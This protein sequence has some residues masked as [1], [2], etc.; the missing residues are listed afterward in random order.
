MIRN[1]IYPP[2]CTLCGED[3]IKFAET[4]STQAGLYL[5]DQY[6]LHLTC[7][8]PL[9]FSMGMRI[10]ESVP[11]FF[12]TPLALSVQS[13]V[14]RA[15]EH[16]EKPAITLMARYLH[17]GLEILCQSMKFNQCELLSIP[18]RHS[19]RWRRGYSHLDVLIHELLK[20]HKDF[21]NSYQGLWNYNPLLQLRKSEVTLR[22]QRRVRDQ[23]GLGENQRDI[24]MRNS[25]VV[26]L[27][28]NAPKLSRG[29]SLIE[30]RSRKRAI[31]SNKSESPTADSCL[32]V[33]D[34]VMT[35]GA[36]MREAIRAV[37]EMGLQP[38]MG[39]TFTA[40][41]QGH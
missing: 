29:S 19:N 35:T 6:Q 8:E 38:S 12:M 18:S 32:I 36:S 2:R 33:I 40:S 16:H 41:V 24:N 14:I 3:L 30:P 20:I 4:N 21:L 31:F 22:H 39:L 7:Y 28:K 1:L 5:S 37:R 26:K 25:M 23:R 34:D 9:T 13:V 27:K 11:I 17:H 10:I 15:K